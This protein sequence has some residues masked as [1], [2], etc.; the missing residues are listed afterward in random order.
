MGRRWL[1]SVAAV[2][3]LAVLWLSRSKPFEPIA[4]QTPAGLR[5]KVAVTSSP[6]S[7]SPEETTAAPTAPA[8]AS[9]LALF[10]YAHPANAA[11]LDAALPAPTRE[12]RYVRV[13]QALIRGKQS[14]FWQPAGTG[15]IELPLPDGRSVAV[16]IESSEMLGADR[17]TSS[18]H[19]EGNP[20][21]RAIFAYSAGFLHASIEDAALG[22]YAL[23]AA[24]E[25]FSQFYQIDAAQLAPCGGQI[26]PVIDAKVL[27]AAAARQA[28]RAALAVGSDASAAAPHVAA[29]ENPQRPEVH[30]MMVYTPA[31]LTTL[32]GAARTAA[33][34]SAFD[35]AIAKTN[36]AFAASLITAR[37]K[38]V[39]IYETI[40]SSDGPANQLVS[41]L[42]DATL[43]ALYTPD[44]GRMDDV[45]AARDQA[46]ADIVMLALNRR[47]TSSIGLSY[48]LESPSITNDASG[49]NYN[50]LFA[51][52]VVEYGSL[53]GT[54]VLPHELGHVFGCVHDRENSGLDI[55][56]QPQPGAYSY[57]F[58]YRFRGA[59]NREY[60]DIMA[61]PPGTELSYFSTPK[62]IVPAPVNHAMGVAAGQPGEADAART[63]EQTAF[64]VASYRLQTQAAVNP[65]TLVNVSTRAYIGTGDQVLI[66][67]FV[68]G[69]TQPKKVLVRGAGPALVDYGVTNAISNPRL[70]LFSGSTEMGTNDD[71][72]APQFGGTA[73]DI[74]AAEEAVG[75]F[76]FPAGSS[77]SA[78]LVQLQPGA[79]T[80]VI[81]GVNGATGSGLV[82]VYDVDRS[83]NKL[84]N[85]ST[86]GYADRNGKE[87]FGGFVVQGAPGTTKRV[88]VR[89]LGP[90]LSRDPYKMNGVLED[91]YLEVH[92]ANGEMLLANDDW[93][94][95]SQGGISETNDFKPSVT[96]Y[97]EKQIAATGLAPTNR[98]EPC[99]MLDLAPG[100]YTVIAKPF[101]LV[102]PDPEVAQAAQPGV[103]IIEVYEVNQ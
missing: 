51:F 13:N 103:A 53:T 83:A 50:A 32:T 35:V 78:L 101:E 80:A 55:N 42:Q 60:H 99:V 64:E 44:D 11:D 70:Q 21:S 41:G 3:L 5:G 28:R 19:I 45:H 39:K 98:R 73:Q 84:I 47:D 16:V 58:G 61:Y 33:L 36:D 81:E 67:G 94:T 90:T 93:S 46:G 102:D 2:A 89:V 43:R 8:L 37:V 24:T 62:I 27:A 74:V 54:N 92:S 40:Y 38:L 15:R 1:D 66:G 30:V 91:P 57:S 10:A 77:D 6:T 96:Y 7:K 26:R 97:S 56:G 88:L 85:L 72:G 63:I 68:I 34:Q 14:P 87:M 25:E 52:G 17:F 82:E 65:G 31:V 76:R 71:W 79:Y 59:D 29:A 69:G 49:A 22:R 9:R 100:S 95:G 75:A 4:S 20:Q 48:V 86:R 23:R 18:G 12:I